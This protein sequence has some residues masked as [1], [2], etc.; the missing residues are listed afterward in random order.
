MAFWFGRK[1]AAPNAGA[2]VPAWLSASEQVGFARSYEAQF[3]EVFRRNPVG[4]RAV[5]LVAGMLGSLTVDGDERAVK[6]VGV[7]GLLEGIAA[8]LLLHG[9]SY[10]RPIADDDGMPAEPVRGQARAARDRAGGGRACRVAGDGREAERIEL[11]I[12]GARGAAGRAPA[13]DRS[14][15]CGGQ[16]GREADAAARARARC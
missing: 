13:A 15:P 16:P 6:L 12:P 11:W 9:N 3:D 7:D 1:S 2:F 8:Q 10:P 4:Q 5:R 14:R